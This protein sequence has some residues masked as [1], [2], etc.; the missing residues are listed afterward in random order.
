MVGPDCGGCA[1]S[2]TTGPGSVTVTR[3]SSRCIVCN[4]SSVDAPDIRRRARE[5]IHV[6]RHKTRNSGLS[7]QDICCVTQRVE[8]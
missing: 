7:S 4:P 8:L 1:R 3:G 2:L 6:A 5:I